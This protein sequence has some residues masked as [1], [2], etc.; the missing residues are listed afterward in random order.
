[1]KFS[2]HLYTHD[3]GEIGS[4][5]PGKVAIFAQDLGEGKLMTFLQKCV[6]K[7]RK[8]N[9]HYLYITMYIYIYNS[10]YIYMII[11]YIL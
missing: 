5:P 4:L 3:F 7:L 10:I 1:M 2:K 9:I 6:E 11:I 8:K